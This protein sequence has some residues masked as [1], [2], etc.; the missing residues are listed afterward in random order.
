MDLLESP[1]GRE[2]V[3]VSAAQASHPLHYLTEHFQWED[4][5]ELALEN[6]GETVEGELI[7]MNDIDAKLPS[8]ISG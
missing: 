3:A 6:T 1:Q 2:T 7:L 8:L 4:S 5:V